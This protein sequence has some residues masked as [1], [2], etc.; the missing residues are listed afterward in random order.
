MRAGS[1]LRSMKRLTLITLL[2]AESNTHRL[3]VVAQQPTRPPVEITPTAAPG[4]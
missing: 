2:A 3:I 4:Q 1:C